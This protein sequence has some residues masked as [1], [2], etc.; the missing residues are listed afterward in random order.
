MDY[1]LADLTKAVSMFKNIKK[2]DVYTI[3]FTKEDD[4]CW[5]VDFPDWPFDHHNLM[6]VSGADELCELL[7]YDGKHTKI[8]VYPELNNKLVNE[9]N[10][11]WKRFRATRR[12]HSLLG[13]ATYEEFFTGAKYTST[14][15]FW[16][17]PVT[18]FVL[19][20]YPEHMWI[21]P[22]KLSVGKMY[23]LGLRP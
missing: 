8:I 16:L 15:H 19:G 14:G 1:T 18:L 5:Y 7:S 3:S 12:E 13:G 6:M 20:K 2:K 9:S 11:A 23:K 4:G 22:L 10:E 21:E 17:C